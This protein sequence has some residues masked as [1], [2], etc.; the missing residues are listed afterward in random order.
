MEINLKNLFKTT[1]LSAALMVSFSAMAD[2]CNDSKCVEELIKKN[3]PDLTVTSIT[4][5][6]DL[7][8]SKNFSGLYEVNSAGQILYVDANVEYLIAGNL[9]RIQGRQNLTDERKASSIPKVVVKDLPLNL[10]FKEVKGK[11]ERK[12]YV[13]TDPECPYCH[14]LEDEMEKVS[15]VTIYR[16][17]F[18]LPMHNGAKNVADHVM[19]SASPLGAWKDYIKSAKTGQ[20]AT[21]KFETVSADKLAKCAADVDKSLQL[22]AKLGVNGTPAIIFADGTRLPGAAPAEMLEQRLNK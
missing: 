3:I 21:Y 20:G 11:G 5:V 4:K 22:G 2:A 6:E 15:N 18:P 17:P 14:K 13:F 19:C 8:H 9:F 7:V 1:I 12:M 16:F 10:A